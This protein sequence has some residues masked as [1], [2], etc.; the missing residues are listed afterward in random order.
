MAVTGFC[1]VAGAI[2][3]SCM[4]NAIHTEVVRRFLNLRRGSYHR[5]AATVGRLG[6]G[7]IE[8]AG[9]CTGYLSARDWITAVV[10]DNDRNLAI[11]H[12]PAAA[13][14]VTN[15]GLDIYG[16]GTAAGPGH[17][18]FGRGVGGFVVVGGLVA[19]RD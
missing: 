2:C 4:G 10:V 1:I 11:L 7:L 6:K 12:T 13:K 19:G 14:G 3:Q 16:S 8:V 9:E 15:N 17:R 18:R 5:H